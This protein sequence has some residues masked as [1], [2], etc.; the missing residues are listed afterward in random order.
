MLLQDIPP[1]YAY[2][3]A[4]KDLCPKAATCLRAI[5][6]QTLAESEEEGKNILY[7][8]NPV[9]VQRLS[10][11]DSCRYYRNNKPVRYAKGMTQLLE[12]LP[13]KQSRV[14]RLR[15]M[16]CFSCESYYYQSRKGE[17]LISPQEQEAI[18]SVFRSAGVAGEPKFDK[19]QYSLAWEG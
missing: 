13:L 4:G 17:R 15:V 16:Q 3:F 2:C 7:C 18:R 19:F 9:Y 10:S 8:V 12:D 5:A 14:V 6:A 1:Y 11:A